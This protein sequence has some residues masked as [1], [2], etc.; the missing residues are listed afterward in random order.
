MEVSSAMAT[1]ALLPFSSKDVENAGDRSRGQASA[2]LA[3]LVCGAGPPT[4]ALPASY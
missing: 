3:Q 1:A 4:A 2:E